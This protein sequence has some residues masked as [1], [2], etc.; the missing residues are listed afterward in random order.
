MFVIGALS[1][2]GGEET[3]GL[4]VMTARSG[5]Q[6]EDGLPLVGLPGRMLC[7]HPICKS[8]LGIKDVFC[9]LASLRRC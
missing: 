9:S 2:R 4:P 1:C 3:L 6:A 7:R 5:R 8:R